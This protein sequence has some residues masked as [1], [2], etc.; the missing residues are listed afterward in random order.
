MHPMRALI[1]PILAC[2]L[3]GACSTSPYGR[4]Q[5]IVPQSVSA[6]YSEVN[7]RLTLVTTADAK[8]QCAESECDA[9][10]EFELRIA[11]L[12]E[13]LADKAFEF[14]PDL[15]ERIGRFEFVIVDKAEP[16]TTS[17]ASGTV[18]IFSG[19][20]A[21]ELADP[22]LAFVL[23]R[24][25]GHVIG[26]HHDENTATKIIV[27]V[28]A[29]VLLPVSGVF[30]NFALLP[31]ASSAAAAASATTATVSTGSAAAAT[32][33]SFLGAKAVIASYWPQQL[34]EA[35]S[36]GLAVLARTGYEPQETADALAVAVPRLNQSS[37]PQDLR[38]SSAHV[39]QIAQGPRPNKEVLAQL[40]ASKPLNL[41]Y[42]IGDPSAEAA[43]SNPQTRTQ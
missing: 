9:S 8:Y 12:G 24:E 37:W 25:M 41:T 3:L 40:S 23:A 10:K 20:R 21:L 16:G 39:A 1:C 11:R 15:R 42:V 18:V 7:M 29:Q 30:R 19:T 31:G 43:A 2:S 17:N 14:Y 27:S 36:V 22:A 35:D 5:L 28:L 26:R 13:R 32:A 38:A 34:A 33:A 4:S 6:V